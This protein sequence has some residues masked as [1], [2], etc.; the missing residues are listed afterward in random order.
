M[1]DLAEQMS[2]YA[3]YHRHP[4]NKV[5]H[6][7]FV[8]AIVWTLM[9]FLGL[10]PLF[11]ISNLSITAAHV[12]VVAVLGYYL[13]L[14]LGLGIANV[15]FF[16]IL[17]AGAFAVIDLG[18]ATALWIAGPLFVASWVVQ[19]LG[20]GVWEK[21]RPALVDNVFQVFIAP[22]FVMAEW[23]FALGLR[24]ELESDVDAKV[25]AILAG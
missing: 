9:V 1:K 21:K 18:A 24:R 7:I 15:L 10:V 19:F 11:T 3:A 12:L 20:H 8:P 22:L 25:K 2:T 4:V 5:I 6:Y 17:M 23:F 16:T 13:Y 14:D